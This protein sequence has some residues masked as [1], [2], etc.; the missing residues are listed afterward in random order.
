VSDFNRF[1][2]NAEHAPNEKERASWRKLADDEI[3]RRLIAQTTPLRLA[4]LRLA[5]ANGATVEN[6]GWGFNSTEGK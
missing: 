3:N 4:Q 1:L 5:E 6:C 2:N